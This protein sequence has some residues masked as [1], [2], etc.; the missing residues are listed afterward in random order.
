[1]R[2]QAAAVLAQLQGAQ[3]QLQQAADQLQQ[4]RDEVKGRSEGMCNMVAKMQPYEK[5][6]KTISGVIP[7][8]AMIST[9][10][11][12]AERACNIA[13][14]GKPVDPNIKVVS[15]DGTDFRCDCS[16]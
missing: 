7:Q 3:S 6:L 13:G 11:A 10:I 12:Q 5:T 9:G 15:R 2:D 16:Q 1:M 14:H 8:M 4:A